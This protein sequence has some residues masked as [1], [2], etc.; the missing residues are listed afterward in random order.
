MAT[1]FAPITAISSGAVIILRISGD[2]TLSCMQFLGI[3][4]DLIDRK[5]TLCKIIDPILQEE[6]DQALI[7][8][9]KGPN[10]FTGQDVVEINIHG[11][12][13]VLERIMAILSEIDDV[14]MADPGE[15]SKIAVLN[16]KM[17][18]IQAEAIA[19]LIKSETRQQHRQ[20]M[21]QMNGDLSRIYEDWRSELID[22]MANLE[23]FIDFPDEDLPKN[24][25]DDLEN[26][27]NKLN[28]AIL[29][30]LD[31]NKIGFKIKN[32]LS[33]AIIGQVNAGKSSL[34]NY[35]A[36]S[37]V[38]IV[39]DIA[40]TTRDIVEVALQIAGFKVVIADTAGIRDSNDIIE[41][42]GVKRSLRKAN[43]SDLKILVINGD[44]IENFDYANLEL[45]DE[46]SLIVINK[47][48]LR[49]VEIP[50][51]I[52][53]FRPILV[54]IKNKI[55]LD[56]L[57]EE[58]ESKIKKITLNNSNP[59]ITRARYRDI[60]GETIDSLKEFSLNKEIELASEDLRVAIRNLG[61][62]SG[63]VEVDDVLDK[64]FSGFC[65]GK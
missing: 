45:I 48:D 14:R 57:L 58:I 55:N 61:K 27:V 4:Q 13:Y 53:E 9:F 37:D 10:S 52:A 24:I 28:L 38:A 36:K 25:I 62:I 12:V 29:E 54:S 8:Y 26:R 23:A 49:E 2:K 22:I 1:I 41:Q 33:L 46:D 51:R 7:T 17:D 59:L 63:R 3:N 15:F 19:D 18:L 60:L 21:R 40:G 56:I 35:L 30:H 6:L 11:S 34:I 16:S 5:S 32:G 39:A 31:D 43:E 50:A 42:E 44:D 65:I 47:I 20:S 64:I